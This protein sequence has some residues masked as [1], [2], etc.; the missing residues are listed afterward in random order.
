ME[1]GTCPGLFYISLTLEVNGVIG[2]KALKVMLLS[3][4]A[5]ALFALIFPVAASWNAVPEPSEP[6]DAETSDTEGTWDGGEDAP[7]YVPKADPSPDSAVTVRLLDGGEV[8]TLS[9]SDYLTFSV[10]SEMPVSFEPEALR[11]QAVA[12]RT[13]YAYKLAHPTHEEADV[14]SDSACC[15]AWHSE[16]FFQNKWGADYEAN[17]AKARSAV[18]DT[19]GLILTYGGEAALAAFHSSSAGK[20]EDS[21]TVWSASLPYLVSVDSPESAETVPGY[22][23]SVTVSAQ[24]FKETVLGAYPEADLTGPASEW[25]GACEFTGSGRVGSVRIGGVSVPGTALRA[26]FGL[27]STALSFSVSG[28]TVT[29][30]SLGYGHGVGMSQ[31]GAN[32]L[33]AGGMGYADILTWYYTGTEVKQY[34]LNRG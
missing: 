33:A 4:V 32:V 9:L 2:G 26:L 16:E 30:T 6:S 31:Y 11:A 24:E 34:I 18:A 10:A 14:C 7:F 19:D 27:R 20:T 1:Y 12:L 15:A 25:I 28:D 23:A 13:F 21:G 22:E 5:L 17:I 29:I 3:S 8:L